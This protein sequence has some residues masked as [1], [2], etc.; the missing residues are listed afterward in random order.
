MFVRRFVTGM[1]KII[2]LFVIIF[3][4]VQRLKI[5]KF[6]ISAHELTFWGE[7]IFSHF[8]SEIFKK[9]SHFDFFK[10][11]FS[12]SHLAERQVGHPWL[13]NLI[14]FLRIPQAM[15]SHWYEIFWWP[16]IWYRMN[17]KLY[18]FMLMCGLILKNKTFGCYL[19]DS[20]GPL[21]MSFKLT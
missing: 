18:N 20:N 16:K 3:K 8:W 10:V 11:K 6:L 21:I 17:I 1:S 5:E 13:V 19:I 4:K 12:K 9:Y 14:Y 15:I 2:F 7:I